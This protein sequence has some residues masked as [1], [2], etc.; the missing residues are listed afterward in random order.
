MLWMV[1]AALAADATAG[2]VIR[3]DAERYEVF[4]GADELDPGEF[5]EAVGDA[6]TAERHAAA[7]ESNGR[8]RRLGWGLGAPLIGIGATGV[9]F[10]FAEGEELAVAGSSA[11][12]FSGGMALATGLTV[13]Y[14]R[15]NELNRME[16]WYR[17]E[18]AV[19]LSSAFVAPAPEGPPIRL[20]RADDGVQAWREDEKLTAEQFA[21]AVGDQ[22]TARRAGGIKVLTT[23]TG[24]ALCALGYN[25]A[26]QA[27]QG[28]ED[29]NLSDRDI[30]LGTAG[31]LSALGGATVLVLGRRI[32]TDM[33]TWYTYGSAYDAL[34]R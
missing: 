30:A 25:G 29:G 5:A 16:R 14:A 24:V 17:F 4:L 2:V 8:A 20:V 13:Y 26:M 34:G 12:F 21:D 11:L 3:G 22:R 32:Y 33:D 6:R 1:G 9:V 23:T 7:A 10:G 19:A 31:T 28:V 15:R 27:L 18:D